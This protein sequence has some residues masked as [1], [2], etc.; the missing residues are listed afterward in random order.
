MKFITTELSLGAEKPF[1]FL[2]ISDNH[3]A[4]AGKGDIKRTRELAMGRAQYFRECMKVL[5]EARKYANENNIFIVSTGDIY[6]FLS[7]EN[8][9]FAKEYSDSVDM[10]FVAGNHEFSYFLGE[11]E[12]DIIYRNRNLDRVQS[13]FKN[14]IR[15]YVREENGIKLIGIDNSYHQMETWQLERLK[16]E[17]LDK[18]PI[19][20]F[21]HVPLY[22]EKLYDY[23]V[24]V[25][26]QS[27]GYEMAVPEE[28]INTYKEIERRRNQK[29]TKVTQAAYDYILNEPLIKVVFAGHMH[30]DFEAPINEVTMQ[31]LT[32]TTTIRK[33]IIK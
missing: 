15:F 6:D 33:V 2:H 12:E 18:K 11:A 22:E 29:P 10:M 26:K 1:E 23:T 9:K 20:L 13:C 30:F 4:L 28:K 31:Y 14:D 3:I 8:F 21:M 19:L 25:C 5:E 16:E 7:E 24:N 27:A 17:A 32:G